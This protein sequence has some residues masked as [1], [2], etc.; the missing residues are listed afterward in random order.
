MTAQ[1]YIKRSVHDNVEA[2][3]HPDGGGTDI[4]DVKMI[5]NTFDETAAEET[6]HPKEK[7]AVAEV[8]AISCRVP[9]PENSAHHHGDRRWP[10][11]S[12]RPKNYSH[13]RLP[14]CRMR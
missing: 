8:V 13:W 3:G 10:S 9:R 7:S 11:W 5:M 4:A 6:S 2:H 1:V 12:R 14:S